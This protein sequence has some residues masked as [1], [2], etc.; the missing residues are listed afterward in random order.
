ML[1]CYAGQLE[2][3]KI[4]RKYGAKYDDFDRG[5]SAPIHWAVDGGN[6]KLLDWMIEDGADVNLRD[7]NS[8]WTPLIR[9]GKKSMS[10]CLTFLQLSLPSS[11]RPRNFNVNYN[12]LSS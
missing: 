3:V 12:F 2:C 8:L 10:F 4:L 1:A 6:V 11:C 5:G 9:C 7:L